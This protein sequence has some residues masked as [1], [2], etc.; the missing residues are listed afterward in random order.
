[1]TSPRRR[2][3]SRQA[4]PFERVLEVGLEETRL[5]TDF[6]ARYALNEDSA[7]AISERLPTISAVGGD[8][9]RALKPLLDDLA[10]LKRSDVRDLAELAAGGLDGAALDQAAALYPALAEM[11]RRRTRQRP[12]WLAVN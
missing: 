8:S 4:R 9:L 2:S 12:S 1:M 10:E 5:Y 6:F 11:S 3:L 7:S